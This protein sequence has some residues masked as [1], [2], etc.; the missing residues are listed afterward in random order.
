MNGLRMAVLTWLAA[1]SLQVAADVVVIVHPANGNT[2][3]ET[4]ISQIYLGKART[5]P[6]GSQVVPIGLREGNATRNEFVQRYVG[7]SEAQLKAYWSQLLFTGRGV[8]PKEVDNEDAIRSL[9]ANNPNIIGYINANK[10]DSSV[11]AAKR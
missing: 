6:D 9:V 11:K 8:P 2:L 4:D 10:V 3:S 5:F 1:S 7:K